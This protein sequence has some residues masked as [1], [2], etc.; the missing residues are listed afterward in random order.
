M[1]TRNKE[2]V[3]YA[4]ALFQESGVSFFITLEFVG[5][6]LLGFLAILEKCEVE[7]IKGHRHMWTILTG[8][9][10]AINLVALFVVM[11]AQAAVKRR[12]DTAENAP[13]LNYQIAYHLWALV[14]CILIMVVFATNVERF[15]D[16]HKSA[17]DDHRF[18]EALHP[19][20]DF[21]HVISYNSALDYTVLRFF[22]ASFFVFVF[23]VFRL[24]SMILNIK[25]SV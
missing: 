13:S 12:K 6:V 4:D 9:L 21:R 10:A 8:V 24:P 14:M 15:K 11:R 20:L 5:A 2:V 16:P 23:V 1:A 18:D 25:N 17:F 19:H 22:F 3:V 7:T